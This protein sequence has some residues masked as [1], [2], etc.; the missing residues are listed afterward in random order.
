M[1][2]KGND[3]LYLASQSSSRQKLLTLARIPFCVMAHTSNE[4]LVNDNPVSFGDYVQAIARDKM[5]CVE[6]PSIDDVEREFL[7]VLTADTLA[8]IKKT[9]VI[10]GKPKD[11]VDG[12]RMLRLMQHELVEVVTG[13]CLHKYIKKSGHWELDV[14][15][16]WV[17][18]AEVAFTVDDD[19][20]DRYFEMLPEAL[21]GC[22][23]GIIEDYGQLFLQ[24]INGS[25]TAVLGLPLFELRKELRA[26]GFISK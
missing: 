13:C 24:S 2:N 8:Q 14:Q 18:G 5:H 23:A 16:L 7:Y 4:E 10:L 17:T 21:Y 22:G 11:R 3:I 26:L 12:V 20:I 9:G 15:K 1:N 6:L 25:Y 19:S